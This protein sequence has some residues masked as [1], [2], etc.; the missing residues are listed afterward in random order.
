MPVY[1]PG[2]LEAKQPRGGLLQGLEE[3]LDRITKENQLRKQMR[4]KSEMDAEEAKQRH[5]YASKEREEAQRGQL[6]NMLVMERERTSNDLKMV[7]RKEALEQERDKAFQEYLN[8]PSPDGPKP[9]SNDKRLG[10]LDEVL[11]GATT[12][13]AT[14]NP[15]MAT[16]RI[17]NIIKDR[18]EQDAPKQTILQRISQAGDLNELRTKDPRTLAYLS[19]TEKGRELLSTIPKQKHEEPDRL[20]PYYDAVSRGGWDAASINN[21]PTLSGAEKASLITFQQAIEAAGEAKDDKERRKVLFKQ[22]T[23]LMADKAVLAK[24]ASALE[25][26]ILRSQNEKPT[27]KYYFEDGKRMPWED[28]LDDDELAAELSAW[29]TSIRGMRDQLADKRRGIRTK[30]ELAR[31]VLALASQK[32][33]LKDPD[34]LP[35]AGTR[36]ENPDGSFSTERTITVGMDGKFFVIPTLLDGKQVTPDQAVKAARIRGMKGYPSF[37]T[38][39]EAD[40]YASGRS[41]S[42]GKGSPTVDDLLEKYK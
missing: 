22:H 34:A 14:G 31:E 6:Q 16:M 17:G 40:T 32:G 36:V 39:E 25:K 15:L 4:M 18:Q 26:D 42:L 19:S 8:S 28:E 37:A 35:G 21:I 23:D 9:R 38:Q 7:E 20:K 33:Q 27:K 2:A 11:G 24:E 12:F 29:S 13:A 30:E 41:K 1:A 10:V 5:M 3:G